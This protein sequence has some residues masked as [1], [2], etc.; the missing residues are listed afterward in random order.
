MKKI[1]ITIVL[2]SAAI[3]CGI[4]QTND[5]SH[6]IML[7][8][9]AMYIADNSSISI[10]TEGAM[11]VKDSSVISCNG[12]WSIKGSFFHDAES[13]VF[14][15]DPTDGKPASTGTVTFFN[16]NSEGKRVIAPS[17]AAAA[18]AFDRKKYYAAFPNIEIATSD[19]ILVPPRMGIDAISIKDTTTAGGKMVL[20]SAEISD[21]VYDASLRITGQGNVS[22]ALVTKKSVI[23]E[24][25]FDTYKSQGAKLLSYATPFDNTQVAGYFAGNWLRTITRGNHST[26]PYPMAN[27]PQSQGSQVI[28]N[29]QYVS[30]W[31]DT[32][33]P[34]Q[35]YLIFPRVASFLNYY[36]NDHALQYTYDENIGDVAYAFDK[37]VFN[38]KIFNATTTEEQLFAR[39]TLFS[40]KFNGLK[41]PNNI[42]L[43]WVIGNSYTSAIS[44]EKLIAKVK[45]ST[46]I[47]FVQEL[48]IFPA[49]STSYQSISFSTNDP[50]L[51]GSFKE[52]PA[53]SIFMLR[54]KGTTTSA[55]TPITETFVLDKD[56]L[57]HGNTPNNFAAASYVY[58]S[59]APARRNAPS[60]SVE[61]SSLELS[62]LNNQVIFTAS[63][64]E[65]ENIFD[66]CGIGLR[67]AAS[68]ENDDY[69]ISK[70]AGSGDGFQLYT[71]YSNKKTSK[72]SANGMPLDA[73]SV[74]MYFEPRFRADVM[75]IKLSVKGRETLTS[76]NFW[77]EDLKTETRHFF[78]ADEPYYFTS[79][80][81]DDPERF[82]VHFKS[83]EYGDNGGTTQNPNNDD[84]SNLKLYSI[85]KRIVIENLLQSDLGSIAEIFDITG[86][87]I[88]SF[89]VNQ[90][91]KIEYPTKNLIQGVYLVR[92]Q[93]A[94]DRSKTL[95]MIIK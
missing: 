90:Y 10:R 78:I 91:P 75:N 4:A 68:E 76:E 41:L 40:H 37:F 21:S 13:N 79:E 53:M 74:I 70:I 54:I 66:L 42:Y 8:K 2:C 32:I 33:K 38:G 22:S 73:D 16:N 17:T 60:M 19:T 72:F 81:T 3:V 1:L 65:N 92:L 59:P 95:K 87:I 84:N 23:V 85:D 18:N 12:T 49:G 56:L 30:W 6:I 69:D 80:I 24:K 26:S 11:C 64:E 82:V 20:A 62:Q 28:A 88:D 77:L 35:A 44:I 51:T 47:P 25:W 71:V 9:G 43:N 7:N 15:V 27:K 39:D 57:I 50:I 45:A 83:P 52:I 61:N 34:N 58:P 86:K 14:E 46:M 67:S 55:S 63:Y 36:T 89:T 31:L 5:A 94:A 93:G 29:D 48:W